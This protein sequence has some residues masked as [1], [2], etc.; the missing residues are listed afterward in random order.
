MKLHRLTTIDRLVSYIFTEA[1]YEGV[2]VLLGRPLR[3]INN[4]FPSFF[5]FITNCRRGDTAQVTN[6]RICRMC[7]GVYAFMA[8]YYSALS[9]SASI[10]SLVS[11]SG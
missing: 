6:L 11:L 1:K 10:T 4:H 7:I 8:D 5:C 2:R 9:A 3:A